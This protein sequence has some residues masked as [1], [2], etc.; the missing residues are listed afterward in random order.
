MAEAEESRSDVLN[1]EDVI[2]LVKKKNKKEKKTE[3]KKTDRV[4]SC[5]LVCTEYDLSEPPPLSEKFA[6]KNALC[7]KRYCDIFL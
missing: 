4:T 7:V 2:N 1:E 5:L 3:N 6:S